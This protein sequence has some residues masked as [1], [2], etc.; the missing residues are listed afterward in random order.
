QGRINTEGGTW[1]LRDRRYQITSASLDF[2]GG[3]STV[4][5]LPLLAE[6][7][8]G[9]TRVYIGIDGPINDLTPTL[10]SE[11]SLS[12]QEILGLITTGRTDINTFSNDPLRSS[13]NTGASLITE[14]F[15]SKP[16]EKETQQLLGISRFQIDPVLRPNQDPAARLTIGRQL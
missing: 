4:P 8:V 13:F 1:T 9:N 6:G 14:Q 3:F 16:V 11:P 2:L 5:N 12:Y 7:D 15:F 10:R